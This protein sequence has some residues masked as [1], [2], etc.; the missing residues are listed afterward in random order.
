MAQVFS[1]AHVLYPLAFVV[2]FVGLNIHIGITLYLSRMVMLIFLL[3]LI[4][5]TFQGKTIK[6]PASFGYSYIHLFSIIAISQ[7]LSILSS[8]AQNIPDGL[9]QLF[10]NLAVMFLF[11]TV[12]TVATELSSIVKAVYIYL[13]AA[14]IQGLYGIY[15]VFAAPY[16]WP[17]YQTL[18]AGI[19]TA[20]DRTEGGLQYF[21][22][23]QTFR[24]T[25]FFPAD[26]SHYS[27]YLA[28]ALL[29]TIALL[30]STKKIWYPTLIIAICTFS[31][32]LSLS[33]SGIVA[34]FVFG[35]PS[36]MFLLWR[37]NR[38]SGK[39]GFNVIKR[40]LGVAVLSTLFLFFLEWGNPEL[41]L[42][43]T[44]ETLVARLTDLTNA[45][46]SEV[47][48][49]ITHIETRLLAID[50]FLSSP[51]IGVGMGLV[52]SP[53]YSETYQTTWHGAHAHH[54]DILGETG[55]IGAM[56]QWILMGMVV[57]YMW[58]GLI[59]GRA[60]SLERNL[61]AGILSAY[62]TIILGNLLYRYY[63]NDFVWFLMG[64]GVA[65]SRLL[66]VQATKESIHC[67]VAL[68]KRIS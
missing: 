48:S 26:V 2:S 43:K 49:M 4:I 7:L 21:S 6:V 11:V 57:R 16:G 32:L 38:R 60:P 34:F 1:P 40:G 19:P 13:S 5:G 66:I 28:G 22:A 59:I 42:G 17:T 45:G 27:G 61:L 51:L 47:E 64:L 24:A 46:G 20:N 3:M 18:L 52:T 63:L 33:R 23:Y 68:E 35:V 55:L 37:V 29:L 56:L 54:L 62:V 15:Q 9:I 8:G 65:L 44:L 67:D 31:L 14:A 10:I 39:K 50:A 53:W 30:Y 58:R 41:E 25:G 12:I 36:L